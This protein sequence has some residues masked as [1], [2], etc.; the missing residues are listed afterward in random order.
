MSATRKTKLS[1]GL[2]VPYYI[3]KRQ[4]RGRTFSNSLS[5]LHWWVKILF[6]V[7]LWYIFDICRNVENCATF[8]LP[9]QYLPHYTV[10]RLVACDLQFRPCPAPCKRSLVLSIRSSILCQATVHIDWLSK[11]EGTLRST[12]ILSLGWVRM[13]VVRMETKLTS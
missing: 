13:L 11:K 3:M 12:F 9:S 7:A 10:V 6:Y 8:R 5:M 4:K 2:N 1:S